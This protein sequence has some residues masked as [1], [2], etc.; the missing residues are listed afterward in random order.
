[1]QYIQNLDPTMITEHPTLPDTHGVT[2]ENSQPRLIAAGWLPFEP[3]TAP[4]GHARI[5]GSGR[6]EIEDGVA[7]EL[8]DT[9]TIEARD[10][11]LADAEAARLA[12]QAADDAAEHG[13]D[14]QALAEAL[15]VFDG[16]KPGDSYRDIRTKAE[17]QLEAADDLATYKR[18]NNALN[19]ARDLFERDLEPK[20]ITGKRLWRALAALQGGAQ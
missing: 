4:E 13:A 11:R 12:K 9:E 6:V 16:I 20:G 5:E 10:Q 15:A 3:F 7:R 19:K 14:L 1:M 2:W 17:A 18:R 8:Y